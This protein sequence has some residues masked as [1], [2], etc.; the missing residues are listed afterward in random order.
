[1]TVTAIVALAALAQFL[2]FAALR[3]TSR[4]KPLFAGI[5]AGVFAVAWIVVFA[6]A[7]PSKKSAAVTA[8]AGGNSTAFGCLAVEKGMGG[9]DVQKKAGKPDEKRS[10]EDTRG[11]GASIWIYRD[12]RCSV[13][14]LGEKVE[15]VE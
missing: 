12:A 10:D 5:S 6:Q 4:T 2:C 15:F 11:P 7:L 3:L 9:D 14:M 13:H 8:A 1:M